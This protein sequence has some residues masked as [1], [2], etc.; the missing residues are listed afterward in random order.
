M[1]TLKETA[2]KH[3]GKHYVT[4]LEVVPLES[5]IYEK[6]FKEKGTDREVKYFYLE[7]NGVQYTVPSKALNGI[8]ELIK[9]RPNTKAV[10]VTKQ[11]GGNYSVIPLD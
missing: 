2:E 5:Q 11:D 6:S 10:K 1:A 3:S 7:L 9:V 4:E 8:K